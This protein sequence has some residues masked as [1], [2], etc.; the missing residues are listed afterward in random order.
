M[1]VFTGINRQLKIISPILLAG[2][3]IQSVFITC[4]I[5]CPVNKRVISDG[6]DDFK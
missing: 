5:S 1:S 2:A 6:N 3:V 4:Q